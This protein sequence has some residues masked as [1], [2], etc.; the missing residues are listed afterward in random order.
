MVEEEERGV[1][2]AVKDDENS[3]VW[4]LEVGRIVVQAGLARNS[5]LL[6]DTGS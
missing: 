5:Q 2:F 4:A 6:G 1:S 3:G